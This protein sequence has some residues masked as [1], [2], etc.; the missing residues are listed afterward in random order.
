MQNFRHD[1]TSHEFAAAAT[2]STISAPSA[3]PVAVVAASTAPAATVNTV[4][5]S[6]AAPVSSDTTPWMRGD[7]LIGERIDARDVL[8]SILYT[9][10][11]DVEQLEGTTIRQ[12]GPGQKD[13]NGNDASGK[14]AVSDVVTL[15]LFRGHTG[16]ARRWAN[17]ITKVN[18]ETSPSLTYVASGNSRV[19]QFWNIISTNK[20][21]TSY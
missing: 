9:N 18:I 16:N 2:A 19:R 8:S 3:A 21:P 12:L 7:Q 1:A 15:V 4:S 5:V 13:L 11:V 10:N 20:L 6:P 14:I 17:D